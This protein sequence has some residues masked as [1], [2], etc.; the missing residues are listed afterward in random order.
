MFFGELV[1][2]GDLQLVWED[3]PG[4]GF[5]LY[6]LASFRVLLKIIQR[7]DG[8][9]NGGSEG[10]FRCCVEWDMEVDTSSGR[11]EICDLRFVI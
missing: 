10:C 11:F 5:H 8:V 2:D 1:V 4:V 6:V 9:L 3:C 7:V